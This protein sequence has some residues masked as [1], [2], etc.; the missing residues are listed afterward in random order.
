LETWR[1][2]DFETHMETLIEQQNTSAA[3][4]LAE[5]L[6]V[7]IRRGERLLDHYRKTHQGVCERMIVRDL[8]RAKLAAGVGNRIWMQRAIDALR[9]Y[10]D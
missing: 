6:A 5:E 10:E 9:T 4:M 8:D 3:E 2:G 1:R 7:E